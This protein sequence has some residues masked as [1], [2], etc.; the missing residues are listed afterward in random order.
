ME[1]RTWNSSRYVPRE[2]RRVVL[3][4]RGEHATFATNDVAVMVGGKRDSLAGSHHVFMH[5]NI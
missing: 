3:R 5:M 4:A 1:Q 2:H